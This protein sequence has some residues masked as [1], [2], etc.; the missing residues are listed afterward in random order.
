MT[1]PYTKNPSEV[2]IPLEAIKAASARE[3]SIGHGHLSSL[4]LWWAWRPMAACRSVPFA[5]LVDD[6]AACRIMVPFVDADRV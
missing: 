2:A 6:P 1:A 5:K 4:H 3:K